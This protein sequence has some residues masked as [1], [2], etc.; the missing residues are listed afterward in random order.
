[1]NKQKTDTEGLAE[2]F[3]R[4]IVYDFYVGGVGVKKQIEGLQR[5]HP[6]LWKDD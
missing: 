5:D 2:F 4:E 1:M 3:I 6:N